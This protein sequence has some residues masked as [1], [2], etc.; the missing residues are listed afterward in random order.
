MAHSI[1]RREGSLPPIQGP[2]TLADWGVEL[3][4]DILAIDSQSDERSPGSPSSPGQ[5]ELARHL[6][7]FFGRLNL[8]TELDDSGNL[9]VHVPALPEDLPAPPLAFIAHLDTALGTRPVRELLS[10]PAWD[11]SEVLFG[12][13][14]TGIDADLY[15]ETEVFL[16]QDLIHGN[17]EA[18]IGL[19]DKLGIAELMVLTRVLLTNPEVSHGPLILAFRPDEEIGRMAPVEALADTLVAA[20]VRLAYTVDGVE[21]FE[22]NTECFHAARAS[23][24]FAGQPLSFAAPVAKRIQLQLRGVKTHGATA[25]AEGHRNATVIAARALDHLAGRTEI[26]PLDIVSNREREVDATLT[27]LIGGDDEAALATAEREL[28]AAFDAELRPHRNRGA[29]VTVLRR[30]EFTPG[31]LTDEGVR[32]FDHLRRFLAGNGPRPLL[33][34]ESEGDDGYSSPY[35]VERQDRRLV[36]D[37]RL[38]AFSETELAARIDHVKALASQTQPPAECTIEHQYANIGTLADMSPELTVWPDKAAAATDER[39]RLRRIRGGLVVDPLIR[40]G[41]AV[42][43]L[44]TGYF[45]PESEK[46][47]TSRQMLAQHVVWLTHLVQIAGASAS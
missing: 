44:G 25:K 36:L 22:V 26:V 47:F 35:L 24:A 21:P 17:G 10:T 2:E 34:E 18:P 15:P 27:V 12:E 9:V 42:A 32:L 38:R 31:E 23:L 4:T 8:R 3:L 20:G 28:M 29:G 30:E 37:Y 11:G 40:R 43:N 46:E 45:A 19:D 13:R 39:I 7:R 6:R 5:L 1:L 16:R 14:L 41:V 33:P